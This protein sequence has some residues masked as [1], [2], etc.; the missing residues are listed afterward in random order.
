MGIADS[1]GKVH[2]GE[3]EAEERRG[4]ARVRTAISRKLTSFIS[5]FLAAEFTNQQ[6]QLKHA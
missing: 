3:W 6:Q 2:G 1:E 5:C 4:E